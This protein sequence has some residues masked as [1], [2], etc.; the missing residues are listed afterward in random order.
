MGVIESVKA[1][2]DLYSPVSGE[3]IAIN[4]NVAND[5]TLINNSPHNDGW[6]IKIKLHNSWIK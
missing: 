3:V 4:N 2:S 1:A 6:L 5:P